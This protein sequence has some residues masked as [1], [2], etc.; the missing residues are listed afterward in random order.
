M[1]K[2]VFLHIAQSGHS[3]QTYRQATLLTL[4]QGPNAEAPFPTFPSFVVLVNG[5]N[6]DLAEA[7]LKIIEQHRLRLHLRKLYGAVQHL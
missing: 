3:Q 2:E 4:Q 1:G 5:R 7:I 6:N